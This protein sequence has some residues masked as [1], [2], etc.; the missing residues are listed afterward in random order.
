ME[1]DP[2]RRLRHKLSNILSPAMMMAEVLSQ[3]ADPSVKRAGDIILK[4]LDKATEALREASKP[5]TE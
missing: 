3:S 5:P 2:I 1:E 4:S